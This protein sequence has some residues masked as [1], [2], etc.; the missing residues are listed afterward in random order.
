MLMILL[1]FKAKVMVLKKIPCFNL[2][3]IL[4]TEKIIVR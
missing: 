2:K 4:Q 1:L 3:V